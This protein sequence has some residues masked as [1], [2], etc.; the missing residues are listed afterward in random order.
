VFVIMDDFQN[1]DENE[2]TDASGLRKQLSELG[3]KL[4]AAEEQN[5]TLA[6]QVRSTEV[7]KLFT[8]AKADLRGVKFYNGEATKEAVEA[9]LK[10]DGEPFATAP[11]TR[12]EG[13]GQEGSTPPPENQGQFP[14]GFTAEMVAAAQAASRMQPT[15]STTEGL[16]D[17]ADKVG[18]SSMTT[19]ADQADLKKLMEGIQ[20]AARA[21]YQERGY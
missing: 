18:R 19:D 7:E 14:P 11:E 20:N 9:W 4:K 1:D 17:L 13:Q 6:K 10:G 5:A 16:G 21:A 15:P 2:T 8:G 3:K 12:Q